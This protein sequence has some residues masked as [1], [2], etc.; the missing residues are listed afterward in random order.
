MTVGSRQR[1]AFY[2]FVAT[3]SALIFK[4]D[5]KFKNYQIFLDIFAHVIYT[6]Y[7]N[8]ITRKILNHLGEITEMVKT[9]IIAK[10]N[11][12]EYYPTTRRNSIRI[13]KAYK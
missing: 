11:Y 6:K 9:H 7:H 10:E 1:F 12:Y 2:H 3:S 5:K 8:T 4:I 13:D